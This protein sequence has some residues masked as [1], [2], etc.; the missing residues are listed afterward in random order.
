M[1]VQVDTMPML[2]V[3]T[4][5][6]LADTIKVASRSERLTAGLIELVEIPLGLMAHSLTVVS[7]VMVTVVPM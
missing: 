5:M 7:Q 1:V 6:V 2:V 3:Q 4:E